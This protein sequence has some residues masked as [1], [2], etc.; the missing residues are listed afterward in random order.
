MSIAFQPVNQQVQ[1]TV[2]HLQFQ[3]LGTYLVVVLAV[4]VIG[5][6]IL[7]SGFLQYRKAKKQS[8][9]SAWGIVGTIM[10]AI[11]LFLGAIGVVFVAIYYPAIHA[12]PPSS[13]SPQSSGGGISS[14][15]WGY[16]N[17][18]VKNATTCFY[19]GGLL[20]GSNPFNGL[21]FTLAPGSS[22][23]K[24]FTFHINNTITTFN[25]TN[26]TYKYAGADFWAH[27]GPGATPTVKVAPSPGTVYP[28]SYRTV[29]VTV[30]LPASDTDTSAYW[31][32]TLKFEPIGGSVDNISIFEY[33]LIKVK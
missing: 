33:I 6:V 11:I 9:S 1:N 3:V 22:E 4:V 28:G 29:N 5:A 12:I 18:P 32:G 24:S 27:A 7:V 15:P 17:P 31:N 21:N 8:E 16:Q 26:I 10:G 23:T 19:Y 20:F 30:S 2:Q 14:M 25:C 13:G